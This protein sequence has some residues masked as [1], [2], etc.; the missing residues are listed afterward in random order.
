MR[1]IWDANQ[2][3]GIGISYFPDTA[4][5]LEDGRVILVICGAEG[6]PEEFA[7]VQ[8]FERVTGLRLTPALG[9]VR[10]RLRPVAAAAAQ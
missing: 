1:K 8:E 3:Q 9:S 6:D 2:S 4:Y 5:E 10:R 7:S